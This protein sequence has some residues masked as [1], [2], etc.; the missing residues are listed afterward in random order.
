MP[1]VMVPQRKNIVF[2]G[3]ATWQVAELDEKAKEGKDKVKK[4]AQV[5]WREG[6]D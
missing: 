3:T 4:R 2:L 5:D 6:E 1:A